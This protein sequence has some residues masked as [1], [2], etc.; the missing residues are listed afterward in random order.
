MY[1][2]AAIMLIILFCAA[3]GGQPT[4]A[5][6]NHLAGK[7]SQADL[8]QQIDSVCKDATT[9]CAE[10]L[11]QIEPSGETATTLNVVSISGNAAPASTSPW[12]FVALHP[13][14]ATKP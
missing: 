13:S 8:L 11:N 14:A 10:A 9:A 7:S 5:A 6:T 1:R 4:N 12:Q 2:N 3:S